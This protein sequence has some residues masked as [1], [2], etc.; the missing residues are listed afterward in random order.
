MTSVSIKKDWTSI[1]N[2]SQLKL[3]RDIAAILKAS[4]TVPKFERS[5]NQQYVP[6]DDAKLEYSGNYNANEDIS[7]KTDGQVEMGLRYRTT[8]GETLQ[9]F[10][11]VN[12][13]YVIRTYSTFDKKINKIKE[14][15]IVLIKDVQIKFYVQHLLNLPLG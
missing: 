3:G 8:T 4:S 7:I 14:H 13:S 6:Q 1:L 10:K 2:P 11:V 12:Y 9:N 5:G 15:N